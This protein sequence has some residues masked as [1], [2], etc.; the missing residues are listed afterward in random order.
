MKRIVQFLCV[1]SLLVFL[2]PINVYADTVGSYTLLSAGCYDLGQS[3]SNNLYNSFAIDS[4]VRAV[5]L[6]DSNDYAR[7][8]FF[9]DSLFL[10]SSKTGNSNYVACSVPSNNAFSYTPVS[11]YYY[12]ASIS[13]LNVSS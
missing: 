6:I 9:K 5:A 1:G 10:R 8:Y 7:F 2:F 12:Y 4:D 11:G 3:T 13:L